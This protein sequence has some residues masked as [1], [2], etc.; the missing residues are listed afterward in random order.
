MK[1]GRRERG[2]KCPH[3]W[4]LQVIRSSIR[5]YEICFLSCPILSKFTFI[6]CPVFSNRLFKADVSV[7]AL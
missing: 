4:I 5:P 2:K 6:L 1:T 3:I 7:N